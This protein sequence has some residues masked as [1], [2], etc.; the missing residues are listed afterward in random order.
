MR[1]GSTLKHERPHSGPRDEVPADVYVR[2]PRVD[3]GLDELTYPFHDATFT[4]TRCGRDWFQRLEDQSQSG[5]GG[6]ERRRDTGRRA[7]LARHFM[8]YDLGYF[9]EMCGV[10]PI[11]DAFGP[12]VLPICSE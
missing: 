9:D 8:H 10:E 5:V 11:E 6:A 1:R 12:K 7:R 3:R 4:G 2:S